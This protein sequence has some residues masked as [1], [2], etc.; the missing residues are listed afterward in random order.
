MNMNSLFF[1]YVRTLFLFKNSGN[2]KLCQAM[3]PAAR[4]NKTSMDK[5][6]ISLDIQGKRPVEDPNC[7]SHGWHETTLPGFKTS[8]TSSGHV[9]FSLTGNSANW[10]KMLN[11]FQARI[12]IRDM[13]D[14][15]GGS[16]SWVSLLLRIDFSAL[17]RFICATPQEPCI[18]GALH[19]VFP[20][21]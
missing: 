16:R 11:P 15:V 12:S 13:A 8:I 21:V 18:A 4:V 19:Q 7:I 9:E 20:H 1:L 6:W 14:R 10:W 5:T 3:K 17:R 2:S